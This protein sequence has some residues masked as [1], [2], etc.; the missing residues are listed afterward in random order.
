MIR[1]VGLVVKHLQV[2]KNMLMKSG[3]LYIQEEKNEKLQIVHI[4]GRLVFLK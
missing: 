4:V 1:N 3:G 2:E